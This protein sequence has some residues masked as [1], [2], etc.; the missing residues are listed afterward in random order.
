[1]KQLEFT[2]LRLF[3]AVAEAGSLSAAA[4]KSNIAVAA[5]SKRISDLESS[6]GSQ[7]FH[8]HARGMTLTPAGR[9]LLQHARQILFGVDRMHMDLSQ[10]ALGAKGLVRVAATGSAVTQFLP[11]ELKRFGDLH[12]NIAIDLS[13]WTSEQIVDAVL[14]GR[15]DMGIFIGPSGN[16]AIAAYPYHTDRL[17][18]VVPKGHP[19]A[20]RPSVRFADTL[21]EDFIGLSP[22]SSIAQH[23]MAASGGKLKVRINVRGCDALCRMVAEGLGIGVSPYLIVRHYVSAT[24]VELV[25]LE[26]DWAQRQL[27]IGIRSGDDGLSG[28]AQSFL[29]HC[30]EAAARTSG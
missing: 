15:V 18:L 20:A 11:G 4:E 5:V 13:E 22:S 2:T 27:L 17:C 28:A 19:L 26:D 9:A 6:T 24:P 25:A 10:Y 14:D 1:M 8:R 21:D 3:A 16:D 29:A 12:P 7:F 23:L 30:I